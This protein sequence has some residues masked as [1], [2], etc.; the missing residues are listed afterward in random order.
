[1]HEVGGEAPHHLDPGAAEQRAERV[2]HPHEPAVGGAQR[3]A[4][5]G[6]VEGPSEPGLG[7]G[8][9]VLG[10]AQ[11]GE[12][13]DVH[14][15]AGGAAGGVA[16][17]A[18]GAAGEDRVA[19]GVAIPPVAD[20]EVGLTQGGPLE[21]LGR[22]VV[23]DVVGL[24]GAD[25]VV[26][27]DA[28]HGPERLVGLEDG[29][30]AVDHDHPERGVGE[31]A[32]EALLALVARSRG[33]AGSGHVL[34]QFRLLAL[35]HA[36]TPSLGA[37]S[38]AY[39][40]KSRPHSASRGTQEGHVAGSCA[41]DPGPWHPLSAPTRS[42][43]GNTEG[44]DRS[45]GLAGAARVRPLGF[46]PRTC[47]LRVRCSAIELEALGLCNLPPPK[48]CERRRPPAGAGDHRRPWGG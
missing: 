45:P 37:E 4:D 14:E 1:M 38:R 18:D 20:H 27:V 12:V 11:A 48:R 32:V 10:L 3:H 35:G 36:L 7:G 2:V 30:V 28:D 40:R 41:M 21:H 44:P 9:R 8:Q 25:D 17:H 5:R 47:G 19:V 6:L 33:P 23:D 15:L 43:Q 29:A 13:G 26:G 24:A 39:R 46:E 34:D 22:V 16:L 31:R 42:G